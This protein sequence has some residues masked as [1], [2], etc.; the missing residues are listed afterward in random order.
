[1][2]R[3]RSTSSTDLQSQLNNIL[4]NNNSL[5]NTKNY[6]ESQGL[7]AYLI[8]LAMQ[9]LHEDDLSVFWN[10]LGYCTD[11]NAPNANREYLVHKIASLGSTDFLDGL[12]EKNV[13]LDVKDRFGYTAI[14]MATINS[15]LATLK[16]LVTTGA[17]VNLKTID[18]NT[19]LH[20]AS[21]WDKPVGL[22][23]LLK[24]TTL[25]INQRNYLGNTP[26][27]LAT[28]AGNV[29]IIKLLTADTRLKINL[30]GEDK[31]TA[32]HEASLQKSSKILAILAEY[33]AY[34]DVKDV[35]DEMSIQTC[36]RVHNL[37]GVKYIIQNN[38]TK[39]LYDSNEA[40]KL[41][42][43]SMDTQN[44]KIMQAL[45]IAGCN[46]SIPSSNCQSQKA[47]W[48]PSKIRSLKDISRVAVRKTMVGNRFTENLKYLDI[49]KELENYLKYDDL[50]TLIM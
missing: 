44:W 11:K 25:D 47:Q 21:F 2:D 13:D 28:R 30:Q 20:L 35:D 22:D 33:G 34:F 17:N 26:L 7:N 37:W 4:N 15:H 50:N 3:Q 29:T 8:D 14:M 48:E 49:P 39:V 5:G 27:I 38:L 19:V 24:S 43:L 10:I 31:R 6:N 23:F 12:V 41:I 46:I 45:R 16:K 18:G 32:V 36:I 40:K 1:M 9:A 42:N